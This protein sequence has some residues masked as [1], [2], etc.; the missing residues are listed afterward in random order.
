MKLVVSDEDTAVAF[1]SGDVPV[2]ATPRIA[3]LVEE[4]ASTAI[5]EDLDESATSVG[6]HLE[7]DHLMP[8]AV[9]D[10]V[11]AEARVMRCTG[12]RIEFH[13]QVKQD[14]VLLARGNHV[15]VVVDRDEFLQGV[16]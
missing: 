6:T 15:R 7:I 14:D 3:A 5:A 2:L 9:G 10:T 8:S 13:V 1:G 11:V 4:A 12:R 16:E